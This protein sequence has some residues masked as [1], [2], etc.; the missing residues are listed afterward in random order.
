M[1]ALSAAE[2]AETVT[3]LARLS[4]RLDAV[5]LS[6]LAHADTLDV[7]AAAVP[8]ATST[9]AWFAHATRTPGPT[10]HRQ[11]RLS[12]RLAVQGSPAESAG[13]RPFDL[14]ATRQAALSGKVDAEQVRV[15]AAALDALPDRVADEDR[16]RAEAHL[17][18]LAAEYDAARL[19]LLA[20]H[21][22]HVINPGAADAELARKLAAEE[23]DAARRTMLTLRDDGEGTCHG[24]FRIPSVH[25]AMLAAALNALA[26]P[27]R[28]D[29]IAR[30]EATG[31]TGVEPRLVQRALP[32]ILG[33]AFCELLERYPADRLPQTGGGLATVLVTL[34]LPLLEEG[35]GVA[36]LSTGGH[37]TAGAARRLACTAGVI[38]Q[39][40][41]SGS[42]ILDQGRKARFH[43]RAQR[44]AIHARDKTCTAEGCTIPAAWCQVHHDLPWAG[45][46]P[47]TVEHGRSLCARH[48]TLLHRSDH[49]HQALPDGRVRIARTQRRRH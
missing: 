5:L 44:I 40:L 46:G 15:I 30:E 17:L 37:L 11:V 24:R 23:A 48:H 29:A 8:A 1:S 35:L 14:A 43:T 45:G 28:P 39:V 42:E 21:L 25:G 49:V 16:A 34:P 20:R 33:E 3:E 12:K 6:L 7:A 32:D 13:R 10:A 38:P 4:A 19:R 47:T 2:T 36:S 9:G 27:R 26:S 41:G 18:E 22:L 31:T